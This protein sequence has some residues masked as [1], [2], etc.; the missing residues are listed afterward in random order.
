MGAAAPHIRALSEVF[1]FLDAVASGQNTIGAIDI[2]TIQLVGPQA[3]LAPGEIP[4]A[5]QQFLSAVPETGQVQ[6]NFPLLENLYGSI[7]ALLRGEDIDLVNMNYQ[8]ETPSGEQ[9]LPLIEI[10]QYFPI[11]GP[12]GIELTGSV[13]LGLNVGFGIDTQGFYLDD[14]RDAL[15]GTDLPEVIFNGEI[16][17]AAAVNLLIISAGGG[18]GISATANIDL[19]DVNPDGR[20]HLGELNQLTG[21]NLGNIYQAFDVSGSVSIFM[22]VYAEVDLFFWSERWESELGRGDHHLFWQDAGRFLPAAAH[23]GRRE[24]PEYRT[25]R[26][27]PEPG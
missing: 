3:L 2:G 17:G 15:T 13:G 27:Q 19:K 25:A 24:H 1:G 14:H 20:V 8:L 7:G 22:K 6:F 5:V 4:A 11:I 18:A 23:R 12:V 26:R 10:S 9:T 21:G 16:F